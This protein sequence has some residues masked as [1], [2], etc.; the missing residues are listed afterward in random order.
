[1]KN[2]YWKIIAVILFVTALYIWH[3]NAQIG[4]YV[5]PG[6]SPSWIL[7]TKSG[8]VI[9]SDRSVRHLSFEKQLKL[10]FKDERPVAIY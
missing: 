5:T 3:D 6:D 10:K 9:R 8:R 7:D 1:M 4:R 2:D